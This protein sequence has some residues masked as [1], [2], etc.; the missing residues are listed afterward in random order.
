MPAY[1][2]GTSFG[3]KDYLPQGDPDKVITGAELQAELENI[4][5]A[6]NSMIPGSYTPTTN[7]RRKDAL[8]HGATA[9]LINGDLVD[10]EFDAIAVAIATLGWGASYT[11]TTDFSAKQLAHSTVLGADYDLEFSAIR[12]AIK[13]AWD[14]GGGTA[15]YW[16]SGGGFVNFTA[17]T[18]PD[19]GPATLRGLSR[20]T[21]MV[22]NGPATVTAGGTYNYGSLA[23]QSTD[24]AIFT[25]NGGM[26]FLN[27]GL[28]VLTSALRNTPQTAY[29]SSVTISGVT[30]IRLAS[31][32]TFTSYVD[33]LYTVLSWRWEGSVSLMAASS[34]YTANFG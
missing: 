3:R 13:L 34:T 27:V 8:T 6:I 32:A 9:K 17:A 15:I 33:G 1:Q 30:A 28:R 4:S 22:T 20:I 24:L 5:R 16:V 12:T 29:F 11:K 21:D 18:L 31:A 2:P 10:D 25:D 14:G 7:F 23:G 19:T 26:N